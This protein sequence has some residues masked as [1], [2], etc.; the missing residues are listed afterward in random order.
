MIKYFRS[1]S[2]VS[3]LTDFKALSARMSN[4]FSKVSRCL[5]DTPN[6]VLNTHNADWSVLQI[7]QSLVW[8]GPRNHIQKSVPQADALP[9]C[10][11]TIV[12]FSMRKVNFLISQQIPPISC[13][14]HSFHWSLQLYIGFCWLFLTEIFK[15]I[16]INNTHSHLFEVFWIDDLDKH[17]VPVFNPMGYQE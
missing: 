14:D 6:N 7:L 12:C 1:D 9:L 16:L 17:D 2:F 10:Y 5:Y 8:L 4:T 11:Y 15:I 13:H 3:G